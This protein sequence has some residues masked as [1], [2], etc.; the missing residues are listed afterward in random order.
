VRGKA[1]AGVLRWQ[2]EFFA[3]GAGE[4][5]VLHGRRRPDA[6]IEA[7]EDHEIAALQPRF[8][9]APDGD[10]RVPGR[11]HRCDLVIVHQAQQHARRGVGFDE[12]EFGAEL[13]RLA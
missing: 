8:E 3:H 6:F 13:V 5:W 9:Q 12:A 1:N 2:A 7:S 10:A 11:L 4:E